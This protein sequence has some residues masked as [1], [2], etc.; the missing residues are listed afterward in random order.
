MNWFGCSITVIGTPFVV[1]AVGSSYPVFFF[2]G[3]I[4]LIFAVVNFFL[5]IETK[6]LTAAEVSKKF[7]N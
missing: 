5:V 4:S 7:A 3:G 2:F 1:E 6:G